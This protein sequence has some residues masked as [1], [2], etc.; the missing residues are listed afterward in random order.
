MISPKFITF[1]TYRRTFRCWWYIFPTNRK[2]SHKCV[3]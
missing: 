2:L 1:S 3:F